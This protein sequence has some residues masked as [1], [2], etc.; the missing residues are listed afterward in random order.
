GVRAGG[1]LQPA[2]PRASGALRHLSA[3]AREG[4]AGLSRRSPSADRHSTG[5]GT[6]A[7][8][9]PVGT[10]AVGVGGAPHCGLVLSV[11]PSSRRNSWHFVARSASCA[12]TSSKKA[13]IPSCSA[14]RASRTYWP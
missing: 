14:L 4:R 11:P 2:L 13:A 8:P 12:M 1:D 6:T 5:D 10:G 9:T 3:A 7:A